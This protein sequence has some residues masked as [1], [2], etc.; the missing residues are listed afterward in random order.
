M[1]TSPTIAEGDAA[2]PLVLY[3]ATVTALA[4]GTPASVSPEFF[5]FFEAPRMGHT[6]TL[7]ALLHHAWQ[8]DVSTLVI[9]CCSEREL[10][11]DYAMGP[12]SDGDVRLFENGYSTTEVFYLDA[13][14]TQF[15]VRP[16]TQARLQ[17]AQERATYRRREG[18]ARQAFDVARRSG[19]G[20][21]IRA[22]S[23]AGHD[24]VEVG[25][26]ARGAG[27]TRGGPGGDGRGPG[28][29]GAGAG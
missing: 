2:L 4:E 16:S 5:V 21:W 9:S 10:L 29:R 22:E 26:G 25:T 28:G 11:D 19:L 1:S 23:T 20:D 27:R 12:V 7:E 3:R 13:T 24:T 17:A 14:A 6:G 15:F 18:A 8:V